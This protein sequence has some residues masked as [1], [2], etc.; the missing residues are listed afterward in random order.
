MG[1]CC[2]SGTRAGPDTSR[3]VSLKAGKK[4]HDLPVFEGPEMTDEEIGNQWPLGTV[5]GKGTFATV[6]LVT[7]VLSALLHP[8][9]HRVRSLGLDRQAVCDEGA[10]ASFRSPS[11]LMRLSIRLSKFRA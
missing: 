3:K 10:R 11:M 9:T 4:S 7:E 1:A 6:H 5:L 2:S 8:E